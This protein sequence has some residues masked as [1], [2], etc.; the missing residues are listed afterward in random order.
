MPIWWRFLVVVFFFLFLFEITQF[1]VNEWFRIQRR[2]RLI[3]KIIIQTRRESFWLALR[4]KLKSSK[5]KKKKTKS[6]IESN[7][8]YDTDDNNSKSKVLPFSVLSL[9]IFI[10]SLSLYFFYLELNCL[11]AV[12]LKTNYRRTHSGQG[13]IVTRRFHHQLKR[14]SIKDKKNK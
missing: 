10:A 13:S 6:K 4:R 7:Q 1:I 9:R 8:F 12:W 3:N 11:S 5:G 14:N 2:E